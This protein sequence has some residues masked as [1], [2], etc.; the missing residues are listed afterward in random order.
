[1]T[2]P[3]LLGMTLL[4]NLN[5]SIQGL[6]IE[7]T[8]GANISVY[9]EVANDR[10]PERFNLKGRNALGTHFLSHHR[11]VLKHDKTAPKQEKRLY[12]CYQN[13]TTVFSFP[14]KDMISLKQYRYQLYYHTQQGRDLFS[15]S[16]NRTTDASLGG[17]F[18]ESS[19]DI[20]VYI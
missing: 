9:Y 19:N 8:N 16:N 3:M 13:G 11:T 6:L 20:A 10:N 15:R 17:I 5:K 1:M 4:M 2:G 18:I 14:I 12:S 7:S